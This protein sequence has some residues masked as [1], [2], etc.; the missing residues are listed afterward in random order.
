MQYSK[1]PLAFRI[2]VRPF[3]THQLS[4]DILF[5][6][7]TNELKMNETNFGMNTPVWSLT[8]EAIDDIHF[9]LNPVDI[10]ISL[11]YI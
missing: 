7:T 11:F 4:T 10:F 8:L 6:Q 9:H 3:Q 5:G 2:I 1:S